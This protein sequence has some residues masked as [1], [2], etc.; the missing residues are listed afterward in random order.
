LAKAAARKPR[1]KTSQPKWLATALKLIKTKKPIELSFP[2]TGEKQ[3][4]S[5]EIP[6]EALMAMMRG[7]KAGRYNIEA[8]QRGISIENAVITGNFD[9]SNTRSHQGGALGI[10]VF[11]NCYFTGNVNL[12]N[13]H[14]MKLSLVNCCITTLYG[15]NLRVEGEVDFSGLKPYEETVHWETS[16]PKGKKTGAEANENWCNPYLNIKDAQ[17]RDTTFGRC[18]VIMTSAV[19]GGK[20]KADKAFFVAP[21]KRKDF[22]PGRGTPSV[23][24]L[25]LHEATFMASVSFMPE[26]TALGGINLSNVCISGDIWCD[27][28]VLE[29]VETYGLHAQAIT[30]SGVLSCRAGRDSKQLG[31]VPFVARGGMWLVGAKLGTL[32]LGGSHIFS[33]QESCP[34]SSQDD[35]EQAD[36]DNCALAANFCT[37]DSN[38]TFEKMGDKLKAEF[39]GQVWFRASKIGGGLYLEACCFHNELYINGMVIGQDVIISNSKMNYHLTLDDTIIGGDL[40]IHNIRVSNGE[41]YHLILSDIRVKGEVEIDRKRTYSLNLERAVCDKKV[42]IDGG[43]GNVHRSGSVDAQNLTVGGDLNLKNNIDTVYDFE[44]L[45]CKGN[46]DLTGTTFLLP[47]RGAD[48]KPGTGDHNKCE[49]VLKNS[50]IKRALIVKDIRVDEYISREDSTKSKLELK[51]SYSRQLSFYKNCYLH[52]TVFQHQNKEQIFSQSL[53][54]QNGDEPILLGGL[55]APIHELNEQQNLNLTRDT[56][57]E[58]LSFFCAH[59][60]GEHGAFTVVEKDDLGRVNNDENDGYLN[61]LDGF[62]A[63]LYTG[64]NPEIKVPHLHTDPDSSTSD[65][66][67]FIATAC[68]NYANTLFKAKFKIEKAG[69]VEML[70]DSPLPDRDD[71]EPKPAIEYKQPYRIINDPQNSFKTYRP[72]HRDLEWQDISQAQKEK[73]QTTKTSHEFLPHEDDIIRIDLRGMHVSTLDDGQGGDGWIPSN[74]PYSYNGLKK[75]KLRKIDPVKVRL[76][77]C[78]YEK[79]DHSNIGQTHE[80]L[81]QN[82]FQLRSLLFRRREKDTAFLTNL[83]NAQD[84]LIPFDEIWK[85]RRRWLQRQFVGEE[86]PSRLQFIKNKLRTLIGR[87]ISKHVK[88]KLKKHRYRPQPFEH[89]ERTYIRQGF[90]PNAKGIREHRTKLEFQLIA[91]DLREN[92][93]V[94]FSIITYPISLLVQVFS[95]ISRATS[96]YLLSS[97]RVLVWLIALW[98]LGY[99]G[100][101]YVNSPS[102]KLLV[103]DVQPIY[104]LSDDKPPSNQVHEAEQACGHE[105]MPGLYALDVIIPLLDLTQEKRCEIRQFDRKRDGLK[106]S[107]SAKDQSKIRRMAKHIAHWPKDPRFWEIIKAIYKIFGWVF[108]SMLIFILTRNLRR[109]STDS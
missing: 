33:K 51:Q 84:R 101:I 10:L 88:L 19:I 85:S 5:E 57:L 24:A 74:L 73:R 31:Y 25:D 2:G 66:S 58:Y 42:E 30:V 59:V 60:W 13:T 82:R 43:K 103:L 89:L 56:A 38:V 48:G 90:Y 6:A 105:I 55:S 71:D 22:I 26:T 3:L 1:A 21:P 67:F 72:C 91:H 14:L 45:A 64:K 28:A 37:T 20:F 47:K 99:F 50:H 7:G 93:G 41:K 11:K 16:N 46:V 29:G 78:I 27:G 54:V 107:E 70:E 12:E 96:R 49:V 53:I 44:N 86:A 23:Y 18:H 52:E 98:F 108:I 102:V 76:D 95:L 40:T 87:N 8:C 61:I 36:Q 92:R 34:E 97:G 15:T 65:D 63:E 32:Y 106:I 80:P 4:P 100:V 109:R 9:L 35:Q 77:G 81:S 69:M 62:D 68:V 83:F 94:L 75:G 39:F 104:T 79:I 17:D